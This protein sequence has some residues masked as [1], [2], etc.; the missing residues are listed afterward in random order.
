MDRNKE[1]AKN[2]AVLT[3]GK[4]C[5][6]CISFL[7]LPLYTAILSTKDYGVFDLMVTYATLLLPVVNWQFDQ[8][9]FRFMLDCRGQ[10]DKQSG[11]FS[12]I[13][14]ANTIQSLVYLVILMVISRCLNFS[15]G[16]FLCAYVILHVYTA[17]LLQFVRGLGSSK[18]YA[19]ASFISA[20]TTV[21]F[22][23]IT[24]AV[25]GMGLNGLFCATL[26]GQVFTIIYLCIS[27]KP[28][29]YFDLKAVSKKTF[30][31]ISKY[32]LPLIPNNLAWWV[33][34]VSDRTIISYVLGVTVNGIYAVA[35]KFSNVFINFYNIFNLS[36]TE[37]VSV[38]F[39]DEDRDVFLSE[40]MT[41]L[42]KLFS[43]ACL[44]IVACMPFLF[45]IMVN[46]N[47]HDAY[48][49]IIILMYAMLCRV[50]VGLYSCVYIATKN[51]KK[52]AYTSVAAAVINIATNLL[53]IGHI[54]LY[55]ASLSTLIAF[56]SMAIIRYI[57]IN[58]TV[59][60][61]ISTSA[62]ASSF[63]LAVVLA[64]TYYLNI[65][66]VNIIMLFL[67]CVYA[68]VMNKGFMMSAVNMGKNFI[69]SYTSK[70]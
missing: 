68:V 65:F 28:W 13:F 60:M 59:H 31:S 57:D 45:P 27:I 20:S 53:M 63:V 36:W 14:V 29:L 22:N 33:V 7:L 56:G 16:L 6:Q 66:A 37:T 35:N 26:L 23:V 50:V 11:I 18:V 12:T 42:Y 47:Y 67:V 21:V 39:K 10:K 34:N 5:T 32:S 17:L 1:L 55:S 43:C 49:Q 2:T 44:G 61:K 25:L 8:G 62:L 52:V 15:Y 54:G 70:K 64:V 48:P 3:V 46:E 58:K 40:T 69:K 41:T 51:S 9:V 38:H 19:M 4:I 30:V 24:L